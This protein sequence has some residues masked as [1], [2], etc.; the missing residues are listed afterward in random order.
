MITNHDFRFVAYETV[1]GKYAHF[2]YSKEM[3][4][5]RAGADKK[6]VRSQ[7]TVV[8]LKDKGWDFVR[9]PYRFQLFDALKVGQ[10]V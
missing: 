2:G 7:L 10:P 9:D 1:S 5:L 8:D 4:I 6:L 3:A